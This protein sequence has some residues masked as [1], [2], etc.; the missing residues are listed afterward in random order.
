LKDVD[1][2]TPFILGDIAITIKQVLRYKE[3][4]ILD[5]FIVNN[6]AEIVDAD[7]L[8]YGFDIRDSEGYNYSSGYIPGIP[9]EY[10]YKSL[11]GKIRPRGYIR[12]YIFFKIP[13]EAEIRELYVSYLFDTAY[14]DISKI[15]PKGL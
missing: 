4:L 1:I 5:V 15:E 9:E 8:S 6:G 10:Y 14:V 7:T 13:E 3:A 12:G 11:G 2:G